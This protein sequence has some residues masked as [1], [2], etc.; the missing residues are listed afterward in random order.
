MKTLLPSCP[1]AAWGA[2]QTAVCPY[3]SDPAEAS[4]RGARRAPV[5]GPKRELLR[6][7]G[8]CNDI[9]FPATAPR[10]SCVGRRVAVSQSVGAALK[11]RPYPCRFLW[12]FCAF[13]G[14]PAAVET[15]PTAFAKSPY[16]KAWGD[17]GFQSAS[18]TFPPCLR[19][20]V[21][22]LPSK[23]MM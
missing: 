11:S 2:G 14:F 4:C 12:C 9:S 13:C 6:P 17:Y 19:S 1:A 3:K 7:Y 15:A 10:R 16:S 23:R 8:A 22:E 18:K 5:P 20:A 21:I